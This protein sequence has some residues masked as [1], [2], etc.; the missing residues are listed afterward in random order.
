MA[1]AMQCD[2]CGA[3]SPPDALPPT[4]QPCRWSTATEDFRGEVCDSCR[5]TK[6]LAEIAAAFRGQPG[7]TLDGAA[8]GPYLLASA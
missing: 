3:T 4:V 7:G 1:Q 2:V 6:T 8:Q 5:A